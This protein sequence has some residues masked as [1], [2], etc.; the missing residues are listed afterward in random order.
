MAVSG[1]QMDMSRATAQF[2]E[3]LLQI[4]TIQMALVTVGLGRK[5]A[6]APA[7]QS[8]RRRAHPHQLHHPLQVWLS[9]LVMD[10]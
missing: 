10:P 8:I 7:P 3:V 5:T 4:A 1:A 6:L 2:R 9:Q